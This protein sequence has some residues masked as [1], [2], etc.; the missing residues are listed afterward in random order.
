MEVLIRILAES[1]TG[2][3]L[4]TLFSYAVSLV[5]AKRWKEPELL[6]ILMNREL[7]KRKKIAGWLLHYTVGVFF[8]CVYEV[9]WLVTEMRP[10]LYFV[11]GSGIASGFLGIFGWKMM[12]DLSSNPPRINRVQYFVHLVIA[13]IIF[14]FGVVLTQRLW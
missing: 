10:N 4:M 14:V 5:Y 11:I 9:L 1:F 8:V 7:K 3:V 13:H 2:I 6:N 12:L